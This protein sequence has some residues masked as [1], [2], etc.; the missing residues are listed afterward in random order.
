M[1]E[2]ALQGDSRKPAL[3]LP[4]F[5]AVKS[6]E[7]LDPSWPAMRRIRIE[8]GRMDVEDES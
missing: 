5:D 6:I 3:L 2:L 8:N 4:E 1:P 7:I